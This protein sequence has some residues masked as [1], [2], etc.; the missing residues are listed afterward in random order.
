MS[1]AQSF[2]F[3][4]KCSTLLFLY[5]APPPSNHC[6]SIKELRY[7]HEAGSQASVACE[8]NARTIRFLVPIAQRGLGT[9]RGWLA[10]LE[11]SFKLNWADRALLSDAR[12]LVVPLVREF[13]HLLSC[14]KH[15]KRALYIIAVRVS[16]YTIEKLIANARFSDVWSPDIG[17][18]CS[19]ESNSFTKAV[20][21]VWYARSLIF[22]T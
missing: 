18:L 16:R 10:R 19:R 12:A 11:T 5:R 14:E 20:W 2:S 21:N 4:L 22:I 15:S 6:Q 9:R 8:P 17:V 3:C 1:Q 13:N 7:N